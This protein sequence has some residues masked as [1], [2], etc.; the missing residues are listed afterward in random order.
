MLCLKHLDSLFDA[1]NV[2]EMY[3]IDLDVKAASRVLSTG[4]D[5]LY[6]FC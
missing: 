1:Y 4:T 3:I 2:I 5:S 6:K